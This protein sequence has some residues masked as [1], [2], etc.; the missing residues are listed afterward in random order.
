MAER[1][2]RRDVRA[3]AE[4]LSRAIEAH[5]DTREERF[6]QLLAVLKPEIARSPMSVGWPWLMAALRA[7][8]DGE[9]VGS[10]DVPTRRW[11]GTKRSGKG[12]CTIWRTSR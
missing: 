8:V 12:A 3:F 1:A 10:P 6:W 7:W 5:R 2:G 9:E 4:E 11:A